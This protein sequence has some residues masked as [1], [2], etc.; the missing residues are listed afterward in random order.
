MTVEL[1][2]IVDAGVK[3]WD[4]DYP[5]FY[6]GE[7]KTK[8]E[9]KV[10]DHYRFRQI[11]QET[12]GRWLHQFKTRV[13]EIMPYYIQLYESEILM[14]N[15]GDPFE[16]YNLTETLE[17]SVKGTDKQ[18][19]TGSATSSGSHTEDNTKS[20]DG[21]VTTDES[22]EVNNTK[23]FSN[24]PQGSIDNLDNYLTEATVDKGSTKNDGTVTTDNTE[25]ETSNV[26]DN[27]ESTTT[28]NSEGEKT[29]T[30][31]YT[32]TR[33]GNIGVQP[34]GQEIKY[35]RDSFLN[36]DLMVIR[37]LNDLFLGVY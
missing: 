26:T 19:S 27:G 9:Q 25:T 5:S 10:I 8:F 33:K 15:V 35:Y 23:K 4:F 31:E 22:T 36:I 29:E 1:G 16:S 17:R 30:E 18:T 34:Y 32:L 7:D 37:E 2:E 3:I 11:G 20:V 13:R 6:K 24:T 12:V 28:G 21:T 14:K